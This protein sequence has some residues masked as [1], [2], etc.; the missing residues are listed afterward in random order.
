MDQLQTINQVVEEL[1]SSE[2]TKLLYLCG[3]FETEPSTESLKELLGRKVLHH[4]TGQLLLGELMVRLRRFDI[5]RKVCKTTR[6]EVERTLSSRHFVPKFRVLMANIS[7]DLASE[8]LN[9]LK[10]LL[11]QVLPREKL[12]KSKSFLD[13]VI[14]LE[15]LDKVSSQSVDLVEECLVGI[16]RLDLTRKVS[17]YKKSA[18]TLEQNSQ[19]QRSR[20]PSPFFG[21]SSQHQAI[22][23]EQP[24]C[25]AK[26]GNFKFAENIPISSSRDQSFQNQLESYRFTSNP[27]GG[28]LIIDCVGNDGDLLEQ[29]FKALQFRV[30]VHKWLGGHQILPAIKETIRQR[31]YT[32]GDAFV[33]CIISRGTSNHLLGTD[34]CITGLPVDSVSQQFTAKGCPALAGKPKL[35][36]IQ[37]YNVAECQ[38]HNWREHQDEDLET[39]GFNG[40]T[41]VDSIPEN[42]DVF[43]SHCWTDE[44]QLEEGPHFSAYL[45][46]LTDALLK[47][48]RRNKHI[49]D[50]HTEVN[51]VIY[52][53]N[54]RNPGA[55]YHIDL[56]HTLRKNLYL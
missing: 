42:A 35:L 23:Q 3:S 18:A 27:R 55:T 32:E 25:R 41:T 1:S 5:L 48:Q 40:H 21:A 9:S 14:E 10:F 30:V 47:G 28:C 51:G 39:D 7:E 34:S 37:R 19:Q 43:W 31:Q 16:G 50:L 13:V 4:D 33:C 44:H 12:E 11:S 8:D 17:A 53:H 15:K 26:N 22:G 54:N 49:T 2:R 38:P 46:A 36:F 20:T 52:E 29:T 45:K 6:D 24:L 56:K